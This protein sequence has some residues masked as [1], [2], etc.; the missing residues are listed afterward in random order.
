[1]ATDE[2]IERTTT[3]G[4]VLDSA[5]GAKYLRRL[6]EWIRIRDHLRH[7]SSLSNLPN[8]RPAKQL[9][10]FMLLDRDA[11]RQHLWNEGWEF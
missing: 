10:L 1:M 5:Y 6:S 11:Q 3:Q 8:W 7:E 9:E 4:A 2:L